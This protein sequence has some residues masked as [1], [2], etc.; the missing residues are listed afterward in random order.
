VV[1]EDVAAE[2]QHQDREDVGPCERHARVDEGQRAQ[3]EVELVE[4]DPR[5]TRLHAEP[6]LEEALR[7]VADHRAHP[8]E[9][10]EQRP[11]VVGDDRPRP[12]EAPLDERDEHRGE[13]T[14]HEPEHRLMG[15]EPAPADGAIPPLPV[16]DER[17][18]H[19]R[20]VRG[21]HE[22]DELQDTKEH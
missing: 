9:H 16:P 12:R 8:E 1:D 19:V 4:R 21:G 15:A 11:L 22:V 2:A 17:G 18:R 5:P 20:Q 13:H 6:P 3:D 14:R 7:A 10:A